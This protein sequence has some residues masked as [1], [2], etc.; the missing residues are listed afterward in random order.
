MKLDLDDTVSVTGTIRSVN[1]AEN[2]PVE[3]RSDEGKDFLVDPGTMIVK[4]SSV[5]D[6]GHIDGKWTQDATTPKKPLS[7]FTLI[8]HSPYN[9]NDFI[10]AVP[11]NSHAVQGW[12]LNIISRDN[13]K[14]VSGGNDTNGQTTDGDYA[15]V[16]QLL[17]FVG[18]FVSI[19]RL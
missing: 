15:V 2:P 14:W 8:G 10:M 18:G 3:I 11:H 6:L 7:S 5:T 4:T 12:P 16:H 1:V 19:L 9:E 17:H 13:A